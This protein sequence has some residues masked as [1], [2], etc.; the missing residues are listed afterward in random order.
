MSKQWSTGNTW[1]DI[2]IGTIGFGLIFNFL[3]TDRRIKGNVAVE[4][5]VEDETNH[6]YP[7]GKDRVGCHAAIPRKPLGVVTV[8]GGSSVVTNSTGRWAA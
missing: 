6:V 5:D 8:Q 7:Q 3:W 4:V 1:I 2:A